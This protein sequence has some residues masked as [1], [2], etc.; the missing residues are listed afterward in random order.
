[1]QAS[2]L[3]F[4]IRLGLLLLA[5]YGVGRSADGSGPTSDLEVGL[6]GRVATVSPITTRT[7]A[8]Q[9]AWTDLEGD[10]LDEILYTSY[11]GLLTCQELANGRVRWTQDLGSMA[12]EIRAADLDGDKVKEVLATA[13]KCV[14]CFDEQGKLRWKWG[15]GF[16]L[17]GL[18]VGH[19]VSKDAMHVAV[20]GEDE[21][22][23]LLGSG[24]KPVK[25][26]DFPFGW[27][28]HS[29]GC[30]GARSAVRALDA[31][32]TDGDGL[33]ELLAAN[34]H[35]TFALLDPRPD[36]GRWLWNVRDPRQSPLFSCRLLDLDGD[37]HCEAYVGTTTHVIAANP[38]GQILWEQTPP[39]VTPGI[40][41][42]LLTAADVDGD[43][44][45]E[46]IALGGCDLFAFRADGTLAYL[47]SAVSYFFTNVAGSPRPGANEILLGSVIGADRNVYRVRFQT[48]GQDGIAE[49]REPAGYRETLNANLRE[50]RDQV[51]AAKTD[52]VTPKREY[53]LS[54][55]G[56]NPTVEQIQ[57]WAGGEAAFRQ[58]Y[59]YDNL[60]PYSL[61]GYV[62]KGLESPGAQG[63]VVSHDEILARAEA[64]ERFQLHHLLIIAHG[65]AAH[66][67]PKTVEAWLQR[68]PTTCLGLITSE[69]NAAYFLLSDT[70][71]K[72]KA[73]F[74]EHLDKFLVPA[75]DAGIRHN[76]PTHMLMKQNWW[77]FAPAMQAL[78]SRLFTP[79]RRKWIVPTV[80]ASSDSTPENNLA[81]RVGMWRSGLVQQWG[82]NV[83][84]DQLTTGKTLFMVPCDAHH[85]IRHLVAYAALG[86]TTFQIKLGY[87]IRDWPPRFNLP[88]VGKVRYT[89]HGLLTQDLLIHLLGK[90]L[91]DVPTPE[92]VVGLSPVVWRFTEPSD[93]FLSASKNDDLPY[94][95]TRAGLFTGSDW[96]FLATPETYANRYALNVRHF[97]HSFIPETPY[98]LPVI[99]PAWF[100]GDMAWAAQQWITDGADAV[101]DGKRKSAADMREPILKSLAQGARTLPVRATE[102]FCAATRR[103]DGTLRVTLVDPSYLQPAERHVTLISREPIQSLQDVVSGRVVPFE[104][105]EAKLTV[106]AGAFRILDLKSSLVR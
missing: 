80:E 63:T 42:V 21:Q 22:I 38:A 60:V 37:G 6:G 29:K 97:S 13:D 45:P 76:R 26:I 61:V 84:D 71:P 31:G 104:G 64:C 69:L 40:H 54:L 83:I 10:R 93:A 66:L 20:G 95:V 47:Q 25:Q 72:H 2:T 87:L 105:R 53:M 18:A 88:M 48:Q 103:P 77:A 68:T 92:T 102:C 32:D 52:P 65:H 14:Y 49:F 27:R 36:Q 16:L 79:E 70:P 51:L 11:S 44:R 91:I 81:G 15:N 73:L 23:T 5:S 98:G 58:S 30:D 28:P 62:E 17:Y 43:R 8:W 74:D 7:T 34:S 39:K 24:G 96:P 101:S 82:M 33:D 56:G 41:M 55:G 12:Y 90:G 3:T 4:A 57:G 46:L 106:P 67:Q 100:Q 19:F 94:E 86:A 50:I 78:R 59:P 85:T 1:M 89:P 99:V 35:I 9:L 75:I